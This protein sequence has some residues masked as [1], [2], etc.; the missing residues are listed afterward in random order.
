MFIFICHAQD[1]KFP[2]N[3]SPICPKPIAGELLNRQYI[4]DA[5]NI[6][7]NWFGEQSIIEQEQNDFLNNLN[8]TRLNLTI[9]ITG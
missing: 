7:R 3:V 2:G 1:D 4:N 9:N 5:T 8:D 6:M